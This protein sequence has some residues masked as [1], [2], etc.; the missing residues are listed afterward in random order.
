MRYL[1]L[2]PLEVREGERRLAVPSGKVADLL[3]VLL[4]RAGQ[5]VPRDRLVDLLWDENPPRT[6]GA[7]LHSLVSQLRRALDTGAPVLVT[8]PSGYLLDVDPAD[9]DVEVFTRLSRE[10]RAQLAA[11]ASAA[12]ADTLRAA[13]ALWRGEPLVGIGAAELVRTVV[14]GW[15]EARLAVLEDRVDADLSSGRHGGLVAELDAEV[16]AHPHRERLRGQLMLAL[17]RSG[18]RADALA[19]YQSGRRVLA[20]ELGLDPG[21]ALQELHRAMLT[22]D[23]DLA[24]PPAPAVVPARLPAVPAQLPADIAD[25][26]GRAK[27]VDRIRDLIVDRLDGSPAVVV[28]AIAGKA[29]VGKTTL[30]VH[31]AHQ[32]RS[33][34]PDGQLYVDLRG[35][36][37]DPRDPADVLAQFV[38]ALS[39]EGATVPDRLDERAALYRS[40]LAGRRLLVVL[41]NAAAESQVRPLLPGDAGSAVLVTSRTPLS[42]LAG[43][44]RVDLDVLEPDQSLQL[45]SRL[46]TPE[47]VAGEPEAAEQIVRWC[48]HLPLAIRVA[49]AR[50]A[51]RPHWTLS[52]MAELLSDER[53]RL[54]ELAVG[55]LE[56]RA[57]LALSC[58]GLDPDA[59]RAFRRLGLL[60]VP[61]FAAWV[62]AALL[63]VSRQ[64]AEDLVEKLFDAQLLELAGPGGEPARYRFHDLVR[65]YAGELAAAEEPEHDRTDAVTRAVGGWLTLAEQAGRRLP[66]PELGAGVVET[67]AWQPDP[68]TLQAALDDPQAWFEAEIETLIAVA[69][70]ACTSGPAALGC[71]F[72]TALAPISV[73]RAYYDD[74]R[75]VSGFAVSAARRAGDRW[76]EAHALRG[77]GE[78]A[79]I[80]DRG[81][82]AL[83][84]LE[85]ARNTFDA[86]GDRHGRALATSGIAAVYRDTGRLDEAAALL[87]EAL[88]VLRAVGD[89]R[90]EVWTLRRLAGVYRLHGRFDAARRCLRDALVAAG[91]LGDPLAEAAVREGLGVGYTRVGL[92]EPARAELEAALELFRRHRY[93]YGE[94]RA[95]GSLGELH[96]VEGRLD[97]AAQCQHQAL[98]L[99]SELR[100]PWWRA[101]TRRRLGD[102]H[103]A[104]G[105]DHGARAQWRAAWQLFHDIGARDAA[106]LRALLDR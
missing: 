87:E 82:E 58:A 30:A 6:A 73:L 64:R 84:V 28:S 80:Q 60:A 21:P 59:R 22:D 18:R 86:A 7:Q 98:R 10:G 78:L 46:V 36:E 8:R 31:V 50:L 34:F 92:G 13:L 37:A 83:A 79:R 43:A 11:G 71:R 51:A 42:G 29:G 61:D 5:V 63:D 38:R 93:H 9:I 45:L 97:A 44:V 62:V 35:A 23:P 1:L 14:P 102:V 15:E 75:R 33:R 89:R 95:L 4:V 91:E 2:G 74:W 105:D 49:G 68:G 47:R 106:E 99:W 27:Q 54:D 90:S 19:L 69:E 57:G 88:L 17:H 48:G 76:A 26:T 67:P 39:A 3:A 70:Q 104:A 77:L 24:A 20:D 52:R 56:V 100:L 65:V 25:F 101:R 40:L 94:A 16:A 32:L 41:D 85:Q 12:A 66:S 53:R 55:D 72:D 96:R 81:S 103:A